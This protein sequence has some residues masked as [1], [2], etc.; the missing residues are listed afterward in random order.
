MIRNNSNQ[1]RFVTFEVSTARYRANPGEELFFYYESDSPHPDVPPL[2]TEFFDGPRGYE[3]I[4]WLSFCI[5]E[6]PFLANGAEAE[7]DFG[8]L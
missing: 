7:C 1:P 4:I 8:T 5:E 3:L 2:E 6:G